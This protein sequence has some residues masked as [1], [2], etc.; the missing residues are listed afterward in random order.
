MI[1]SFQLTL[2]I[3]SKFPQPMVLKQYYRFL[4][5]DQS[6]VRHDHCARLPKHLKILLYH[7]FIIRLRTS[8]PDS[9]LQ[10]HC[11]TDFQ[12]IKIPLI[13]SSSWFSGFRV[14][15]LINFCLICRST[16]EN[17][18]NIISK[19]KNSKFNEKMRQNVSG[20]CRAKIKLGKLLGI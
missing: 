18:I 7:T 9:Q 10:I 8:F 13:P 17:S 19:G 4:P 14:V 20:S 15:H 3:L 5:S 12:A 16:S 6:Q 1:E 2:N 11:V